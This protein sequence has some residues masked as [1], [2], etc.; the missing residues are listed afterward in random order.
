ML[1]VE[2]NSLENKNMF[3][4]L[5]RAFSLLIASYCTSY[6]FADPLIADFRHFAR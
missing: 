5:S 2:D 6:T 3:W 4:L 1:L